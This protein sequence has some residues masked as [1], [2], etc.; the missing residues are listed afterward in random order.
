MIYWFIPGTEGNVE[1]E[2]PKW[3][4]AKGIAFEEKEKNQMLLFIGWMI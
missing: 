2:Q 3:L 1:E 4:R